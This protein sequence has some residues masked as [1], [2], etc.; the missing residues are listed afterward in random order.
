[1]TKPRNSTWTFKGK[2]ITTIPDEYVGFVYLIVNLT[3]NRCYIGKKL[4]KFSKVKYKMVKLKNGTKKRKKIKELVDSDWLTYWSSSVDVQNDV[5]T[6][7]EDNFTRTILHMCRTKGDLSYMEL[8][9]QV[10]RGVLEDD[11]YYNGIIQCRIHK[12]HISRES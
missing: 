2:E 3:N 1:M 8:K 12:N 4:A 10:E 9:E 5:K 11:N 7:G 6:Y